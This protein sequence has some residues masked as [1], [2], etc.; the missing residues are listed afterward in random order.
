M[1]CE[2]H[3]LKMFEQEM[4][5]ES[6]EML[7]DRVKIAL[8]RKLHEVNLDFVSL[9]MFSSIYERLNNIL[10]LTAY[11]LSYI[12]TH[13]KSLEFPCLMS[14]LINSDKPTEEELLAHLNSNS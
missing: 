1:V 3:R 8:A 9:A 2:I 11:I 4:K 12:E 10:V 13:D 7:L 14:G 5:Y 6:Q